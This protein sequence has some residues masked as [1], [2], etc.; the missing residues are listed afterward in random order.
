MMQIFHVQMTM[1]VLLDCILVSTEIL[2]KFTRQSLLQ[3]AVQG[4]KKKKYI[5][6]MWYTFLFFYTY[7]PSGCFKYL[8]T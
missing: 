7:L 1:K 3:Q 8:L 4:G 6:L 5:Y 2:K